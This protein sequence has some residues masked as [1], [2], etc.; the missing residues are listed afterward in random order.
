MADAARLK[1]EDLTPEQLKELGIKMPRKTTFTKEDIRSWAL[2]ILAQMSCLTQEQ[3]RRVME[4]ALKVN[5]M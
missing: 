2:K 4:H 5:R 1:I 3:R